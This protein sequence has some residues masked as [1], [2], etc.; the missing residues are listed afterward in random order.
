MVRKTMDDDDLIKN[1]KQGIWREVVKV[2]LMKLLGM[3]GLTAATHAP[4]SSWLD[5]ERF[6]LAQGGNMMIDWI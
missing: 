3:E 1:L 5:G 2:K 4:R 6:T